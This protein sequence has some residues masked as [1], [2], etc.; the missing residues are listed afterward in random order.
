MNYKFFN[1]CIL[2]NFMVN[3]AN[4]FIYIFY[5]THNVQLG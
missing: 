3:D 4:Y 5:V 2:L 1:E